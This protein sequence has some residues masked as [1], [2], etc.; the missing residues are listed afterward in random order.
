MTPVP[1]PE[2]PP[3]VWAVFAIPVCPVVR[4]LSRLE[5]ILGS[6]ALVIQLLCSPVTPSVVL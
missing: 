6:V 4:E 5:S 2:W 3:V 1:A